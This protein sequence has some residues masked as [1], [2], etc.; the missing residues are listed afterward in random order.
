MVTSQDVVIALSNSGET[1]ELNAILPV[2]KRIGAKLISLVG[3][4]DSTL[5]RASDVVLDVSVGREACPLGLAPTASTTAM[6]AL[7]DALALAAMEERE[8]T[9]EDYAIFHPSGTLGRRLTLKVSDVMRTDD[10]M[11]VASESDLVRDVLFAITKA[12]AGAAAITD[13]DGEL[14]GI[15]TDGDLRR[16]ILADDACLSRRAAE[17]MTRDPRVVSPDQFAT[18][19]MRILEMY[20][21][22]DL[23]VLDDE[24]HPVGMLMLKDLFRAGIV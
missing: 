2:L 12:G 19:G 14:V 9:A 21:L 22:G 15:I 3:R 7:G 24:R 4:M 20:K 10:R 13:A 1:D 17:I 11:A 16:H 8:F 6:L 23:P 5:A 18:E